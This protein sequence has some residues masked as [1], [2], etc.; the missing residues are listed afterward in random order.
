M[1]DK[2]DTIILQSDRD[3]V[4]ERPGMYIGDNSEIG[5]ATIV[6]EIIDNAVDEY[7]NYSD[8]T[9]PIEV[10][11]HADNSLSVRDHGRGISPYESKKYKGKIEERLAY[12]VIGAGGKFKANREQNGNKFSGGLNGTGSAATN[13]MSEFFDVTI[14][15]DGHIFHDRFENGGIPVE[16]LVNGQL[17]KKKQ[18]G[19][20]E[21]GT[22]VHFKADSTVMRVTTINARIL[23]QYF[24]QTAYLHQG[25]HILFTNERDGDTEPTDYYSENGLFDYINDL[26]T[27]ENGQVVD[28]LIKPFDVRGCQSVTVLD[29]EIDME[30]HI[31]VAFTKNGQ[32]ATESFTNGIHNSLGGTHVAGFNNGLLRLLK[33]YYDEFSD[34]INKKYKKQ[35]DLIKKVNKVDD[36]SS[37]FKSRDL[38][39][40]VF[41]VIDFKHSNPILQPQTKDKL[42]SD[43]A[44]TAVSNIFYDNAMMYLDKNITAVQ[45]LLNDVIAEM[46][47]KAKDEDSNIQ[48]D[49]KTETLAKS[50]K[51]AAARG[52]YPEL[53][54]LILVEGDSAAGSLKAN[55][56]ANFQAV[57]PLR[58][59]VLNVQKATLKDALANLEISTIFSILGCGYGRNYDESK[60]KY[61]KII[62]AT[63]QDVDGLH[64]RTLLLTLFLKYTKLVQQ[65]HVYFL[66][67][68][69][70]VNSVKP[71]KTK[72]EKEVYTYSNEEQNEF[73][74]ANR[75]RIIEVSRNKGLGEL[76]TDQVIT[77]ILTPET[78]K[79]TQIVITEDDEDE[80]YEI[81][82]I[83]MGDDAQGRK[84]MIENRE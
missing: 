75:K 10:I 57:L 11:L 3:K 81:V 15:K 51:L 72:P 21:T 44:R 58:G 40:R 69:L 8:P 77:T 7:P 60:L 1:S 67:T 83:L 41:V 71:T 25:L 46:Y 27:D 84:R 6:R 73:L 39:K 33:H 5:L 23:E 22:L 55:R 32:F 28:F 26:A 31:A 37:L 43:E 56:D 19:T 2:T 12:T 47:D 79:L 42:A 50:T 52:T 34:E 13:F 76:S 4:R 9:K 24:R 54:E 30:A 82:E 48:I 36:V 45:R 49:K 63:D 16:K 20:P 38:A 64:I 29:E 14:F 35:I 59:K 80:A 68:P 17:P 74:E 53:M 62:I 61:Q 65:G 18:K 70:F 66:D 78:R